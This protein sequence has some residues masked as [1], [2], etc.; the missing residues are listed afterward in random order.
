M[1]SNV[2]ACV[3][4]K[5]QWL[6]CRVLLARPSYASSSIRPSPCVH[7][8]NRKIAL[9]PRCCRASHSARPKSTELA[10]ASDWSNRGLRF[11]AFA[12]FAP[13]AVVVNAPSHLC[14]RV[15]VT[16]SLENEPVRASR[17]DNN[18]VLNV[19]DDA[20]R[21]VRACG[22]KWLPSGMSLPSSLPRPCTRAASRVL[23]A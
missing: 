16:A 14:A 20:V 9:F 7:P 2:F 1:V 13:H 3:L 8:E 11:C 12:R 4:S 22:R 21:V 6:S 23:T 15:H 17:F 19:A 18:V 5:F 10:S